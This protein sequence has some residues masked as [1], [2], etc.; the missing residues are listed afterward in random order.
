MPLLLLLGGA[1][2][3]GLL[4]EDGGVLLLEDGTQLLPE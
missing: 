4:S 3:T 2:E 1:L